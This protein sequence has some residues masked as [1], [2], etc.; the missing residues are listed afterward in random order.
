VV[1]SRAYCAIKK[2]MLMVAEYGVVS[3][4]V[5][6]TTIRATSKEAGEK[7]NRVAVSLHLF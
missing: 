3:L 4:M 2:K 5:F 6:R 7:L 1:S